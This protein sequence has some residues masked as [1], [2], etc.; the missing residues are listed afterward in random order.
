MLEDMS[1]IE[2]LRGVEQL[3]VPRRAVGFAIDVQVYR[4]RVAEP[5]GI[6]AYWPCGRVTKAQR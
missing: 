3:Q 2:Q 1:L 6:Y 4:Y 5:V